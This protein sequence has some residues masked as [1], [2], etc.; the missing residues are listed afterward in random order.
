MHKKTKTMT[1]KN[2]T[3]KNKKHNKTKN[4][5]KILIRNRRN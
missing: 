2:T 4:N 3:K 1:N 5:K